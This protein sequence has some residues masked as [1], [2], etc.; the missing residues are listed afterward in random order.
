[1]KKIILSAL[2][3]ACMLT[4]FNGC[5][6]KMADFTIASTSSVDLNKKYTLVA[7]DVSSS[8]S[9]LFVLIYWG[10]EDM[11]YYEAMGQCMAEHDGDLMTDVK[12]TTSSYWFIIGAYTN[13]K[14]EGHVWKCV[15]EPLMSLYESDELFDIR[16]I[17]GESFLVSGDGSTSH[18]VDP[19]LM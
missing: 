9:S 13:Y 10:A 14:V 12:V 4:L 1:M 11:S 5:T 18:K 17:E 15:E 8:T 3:I 19:A 2:A 6:S 7:S 16:E